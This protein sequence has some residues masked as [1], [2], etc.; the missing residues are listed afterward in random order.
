MKTPIT[1]ATIIAVYS[2]DAGPKIIRIYDSSEQA[3]A[4]K[5]YLDWSATRSMSYATISYES[6]RY[7]RDL[8]DAPRTTNDE[9]WTETRAV[10]RG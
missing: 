9:L 5:A 8:A 10:L 7:I 6:A 2:V 4:N 1:N 3:E